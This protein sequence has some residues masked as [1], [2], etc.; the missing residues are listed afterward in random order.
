MNIYTYGTDKR[1]DFCRSYLLKAG[2]NDFA[3]ITI[4][5]IPSTKD[6]KTVN[7]TEVSLSEIVEK[8]QVS[9]LVVGY[10]L[11]KS[12]RSALVSR[13][14]FVVDVSR[15]EGFLLDNAYL[16]AVGTL[17]RI[18]S[19][20]A[21]A[22]SDLSIGVIG[23]GRIGER[24]VSELLFLSAAVTVFTSK[25]ELSRELC[26]LGVSGVPYSSLADTETQK[27]LAGLDILINTAPSVLIP[28]EA[29]C[30]LS[31]VRV[32]ELASG[33]NFPEGLYYERF[34][35]V[36]AKMYPR[37]AGRALADSVMRMLGEG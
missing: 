21:S 25:T 2:L 10:A 34:S 33:N 22:P 28:S 4:L 14:A 31:G 19:E 37:S 13:G 17:G 5:P 12:F 7:G 15:D 32:I 26:M 27:K 36:P 29:V 9:D 23:Y 18:L 24:L 1:L 3:N 11:P 20:E 8:T 30:Y 6:E 16:T 35:S